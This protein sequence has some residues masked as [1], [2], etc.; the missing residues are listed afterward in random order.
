MGDILI[1]QDA[2]KRWLR[3]FADLVGVL[4]LGHSSGKSIQINSDPLD[5]SNVQWLQWFV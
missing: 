2:I 3:T 5:G 4:V 1:A